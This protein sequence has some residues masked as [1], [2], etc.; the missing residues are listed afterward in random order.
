MSCIVCVVTG[1]V[2]DPSCDH[3][4]YNNF[5]SQG[6]KSRLKTFFGEEIIGEGCFDLQYTPFLCQCQ[7]LCR[8]HYAIQLHR[9]G[10]FLEFSF[11]V[12]FKML[13]MTIT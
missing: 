7:M 12:S 3:N 13:S 8:G 10:Q 2:K 11:F 4:D 5:L 9:V 1:E 6:H